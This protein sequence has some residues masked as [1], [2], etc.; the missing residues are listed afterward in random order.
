MSI[1]IVCVCAMWLKFIWE[2]I[3][4]G[5]ISGLFRTQMKHMKI[6]TYISDSTITRFPFLKTFANEK[7]IELN[8][9][10]NV[11]EYRCCCSFDLIKLHPSSFSFDTLSNRERERERKKKHDNIMCEINKNQNVNN[12]KNLKCLSCVC[13]VWFGWLVDWIV[14]RIVHFGMLVFYFLSI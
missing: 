4:W 5:Y 12:N 3:F 9:L 7:R 13:V 6:K 14:M 10:W 2:N 1:S 11:I 8:W